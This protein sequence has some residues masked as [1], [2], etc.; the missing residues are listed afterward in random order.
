MGAGFPSRCL[1]FCIFH[2][3][4]MYLLSLENSYQVHWFPVVSVRQ[5]MFANAS[6]VMCLAV[7]GV[8]LKTIGNQLNGNGNMNKSYEN[9]LAPIVNCNWPIFRSHVQR[10]QPLR[11]WRNNYAFSAVITLL[12]LILRSLRFWCV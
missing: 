9:W 3:Y 7:R 12:R 4:N 11:F 10:C 8:P 1:T 5:S 2:Q 6:I